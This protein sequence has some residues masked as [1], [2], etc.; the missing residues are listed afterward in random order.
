MGFEDGK[1]WASNTILLSTYK[2]EFGLINSIGKVQTYALPHADNG[3]LFNNVLLEHVKYQIK[4][5]KRD[6]NTDYG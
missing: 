6:H 2:Y 1:G 4:I 3:P 5:I